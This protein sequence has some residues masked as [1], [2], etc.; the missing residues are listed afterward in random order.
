MSVYTEITMRFLFFSARTEL[1]KKNATPLLC[2]YILTTVK[3]KLIAIN[4]ENMKAFLSYPEQNIKFA[5][6]SQRLLWMKVN[7]KI[8]IQSFSYISQTKM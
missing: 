6:P 2:A 5:F 3:L 4:K 1:N 8:K 7:T